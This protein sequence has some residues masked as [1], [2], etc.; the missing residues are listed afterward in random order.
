MREQKLGPNGAMIYCME[1]LAENVSWL[2]SQLL[3]YEED[4]CYV[5]FDCPGQIE[6]YTHDGAVPKLLTSLL[7]RDYRLCAVNLMDS[8]HCSDA[9]KFIS[10]LLVTLRTMLHLELPQ[11]N[12]LSKIDI[13]E[14][15]G[16]CDFNLDFYTEVMDLRY[17]YLCRI[18]YIIK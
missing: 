14:S 11:V 10:V 2:Q 7:S 4:G 15:Q 6:L 18:L 8:F 1:Y 9:A 13:F 3:S 16:K 5:L 17:N 12:V